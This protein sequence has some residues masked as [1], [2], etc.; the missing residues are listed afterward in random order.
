MALDALQDDAL[1][2]LG[3]AAPKAL[4]GEAKFVSCTAC[5][6]GG[7]KRVLHPCGHAVLCGDCLREAS[8]CPLCGAALASEGDATRTPPP[9]P[10]REAG[11]TRLSRGSP[12]AGA[13]S[14][15]RLY[16]ACVCAGLAGQHTGLGTWKEGANG[17]ASPAD[18][19]GV[20]SRRLAPEFEHAGTGMSRVDSGFALGTGEASEGGAWTRRGRG[21]GGRGR[22]SRVH[23][24]A[25]PGRSAPLCAL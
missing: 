21:S 15:L 5:H 2:R 12:A 1:E 17:A 13:G 10:A 7:V 23:L 6:K 3:R 22:G 24:G 11:P 14:A 25:A 4:A 16:D 9:P 8:S 18:G 19:L 20:A